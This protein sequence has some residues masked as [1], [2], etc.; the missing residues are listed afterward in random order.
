MIYGVKRVR[1]LI[2]SWAYFA[3]CVRQPKLQ[4]RSFVLRRREGL[5]TRPCILPVLATQPSRNCI[6]AR[7]Y[8]CVVVL[9]SQWCVKY[10]ASPLIIRWLSRDSSTSAALMRVSSL[11]K[12]SR[13]ER[14]FRRGVRRTDDF[15]F[16]TTSRSETHLRERIV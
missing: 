12:L 5:R 11:A 16:F 1:R 2:A 4:I 15:R 13:Y 6:L 8:V 10:R 9:C 14:G 7:D 3:S